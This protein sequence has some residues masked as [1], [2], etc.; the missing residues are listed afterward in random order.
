MSV[1]RSLRTQSRN[2]LDGMSLEMIVR[3]FT[4]LCALL[5]ADSAQTCSLRRKR[6]DSVQIQ[7]STPN[8]ERS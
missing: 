1:R 4:Y 2:R 6:S 8:S 3:L 5:N 7:S